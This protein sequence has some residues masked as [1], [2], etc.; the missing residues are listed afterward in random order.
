MMYY[1]KLPMIWFYQLVYRINPDQ[2]QFKGYL[3]HYLSCLG[4][5]EVSP[6]LHN[7]RVT[8]Q[9]NFLEEYGY[10]PDFRGAVFIAGCNYAQ[11]MLRY[12]RFH[13]CLAFGETL[14]DIFKHRH[15]F[16]TKTKPVVISEAI[17]RNELNET[18]QLARDLSKAI[19][20]L[21]SHLGNQK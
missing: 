12:G 11:G 10:K 21:L 4:F 6:W 15:E 7:E 9:L 16:P 20:L 3:T 13:R 2:E 1:L 18:H 8:K 14:A 5:K 17:A 19:D